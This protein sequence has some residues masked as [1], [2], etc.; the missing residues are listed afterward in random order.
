MFPNMQQYMKAKY[1]NL[2]TVEM[3]RDKFIEMLEAHG[4]TREE[5]EMQLDVGLK[6][7]ADSMVIGDKR[8]KIVEQAE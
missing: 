2:P 5:A 8:Y 7:G 6:L 3:T 4:K 1:G